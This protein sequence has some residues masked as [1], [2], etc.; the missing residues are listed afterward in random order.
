M[1][2]KDE[3]TWSVSCV[4]EPDTTRTVVVLGITQSSS[5]YQLTIDALA[6]QKIGNALIEAAEH[7]GKPTI[8]KPSVSDISRLS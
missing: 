6:A 3:F 2:K 1:S 7:A 8:L 4:V 5:I